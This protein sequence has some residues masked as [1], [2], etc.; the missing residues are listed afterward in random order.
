M[1]TR[2]LSSEKLLDFGLFK[3]MTRR[4]LPHILVAFL[5]NF[6]TVSVPILMWGDDLFNRF[7]DY[8]WSMQDFLERAAEKM[9]GNMT[10]NLVLMF[11]LGIYFG[12]ISLGYMMKRRSAHFYHALPEKRE[13]LYTTSVVSALFCAAIGALI[14][15]MIILVELSVYSIFAPQVLSVFF[16]LMAKNILYFLMAYAITVFAGS[17]SGYGLVQVLMT[18]VIFFYPVLT[19]LGVLMLRAV[20]ATYFNVEFYITDTILPWFS[21][22]LYACWHYWGTFKVLPTVIGILVIAALLLG[23]MAIYRKRAIENSERP[24]VFKP[25]GTVLKFMFMFTVTMYAGLFFYA[26]SYSI[27]YAVFGFVCGAV[28]SFMLFNTILAKSPKAMFKGVKGLIIFV[29]AFALFYAVVGLDVLGMDDYVPAEDNISFAE[30]EVSGAGYENSRFDDP[31]IL[32]ALSKVLK[33]QNTV[34]KQNLYS[35]FERSGAAFTV[36]ATMYTKLGVPIARSYY[37]SKATAGAQEFLRLYANDARMQALFDGDIETYRAYADRLYQMSFYYADEWYYRQEASI[38]DFLAVYTEEIGAFNYD[39][40][41][42]PTIGYVEILFYAK[43]GGYVQEMNSLRLEY[44]PLYED[45]T[46]TLAFLDDIV[47]AD[48]AASS[49]DDA[50]TLTAGYVCDMQNLLSHGESVAAVSPY[51]YIYLDAYPESKLEAEYAAE[52]YTQLSAYSNA[53]Y[54]SRIFFAI[55]TDYVFVAKIG[56][57][58][59][60]TDRTVEYIDQ[61][62]DTASY[63]VFFFPAGFD[64][65]KISALFD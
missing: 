27:F 60:D 62:A 64:M 40:L 12:V 22:V 32:A 37:V 42:Q 56:G 57:A 43:D 6:F 19:Y 54:F 5:V 36:T 38:S 8:E 10:I 23:G 16:T 31:E 4:R 39:R 11:I 48:S 24:I 25:L 47:A 33:E 52:I 50:A 26:I 58:D 2:K 18:L 17:F 29:I 20:D 28:L 51:D 41:S 7:V 1:T 14:N 35:P 46:K 34:D 53:S 49:L 61:L 44:F 30:I 55:N 59:A 9:Q 63:E 3:N 21:P 15:L 13:T 45:M 65:T